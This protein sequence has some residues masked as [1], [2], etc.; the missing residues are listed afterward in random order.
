MKTCLLEYYKQITKGKGYNLLSDQA[1]EECMKN[2]GVQ[3]EF[4][5]K[6]VRCKH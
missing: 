4:S 1:I 2:S 5:V 6:A 3:I